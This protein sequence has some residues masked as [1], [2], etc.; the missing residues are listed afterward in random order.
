MS[1]K[2]RETNKRHEIN[3]K[4]TNVTKMKKSHKHQS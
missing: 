4:P 1:L 3:K 2:Y